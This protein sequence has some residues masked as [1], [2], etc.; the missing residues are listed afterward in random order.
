M[1]HLLYIG[2]LGCEQLYD[3]YCL[4]KLLSI[5]STCGLPIIDVIVP[6]RLRPTKNFHRI[7][8]LRP[9]VKSVGCRKLLYVR[10]AREIVS[11]LEVTG[12]A[13][14]VYEI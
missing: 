7:S 5:E 8:L 10:A 1:R 4:L 13:N 3:C 6:A 11:C 14:H 9:R 2:Q 12:R